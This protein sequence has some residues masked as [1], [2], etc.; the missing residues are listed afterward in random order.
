MTAAEKAVIRGK[1]AR[2]SALE[3]EVPFVRYERLLRS[4]VSSP[5]DENDGGG[6]LVDLADYSVGEYLP[7]LIF[8]ALRK[9]LSHRE[10]R[11]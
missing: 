4:R 3:Y 5:K 8:M 9:T 10:S 1:G 2:V 7:A 11:V 6:L